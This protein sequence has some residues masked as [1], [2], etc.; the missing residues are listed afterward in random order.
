[1]DPYDFQTGVELARRYGVDAAEV[2]RYLSLADGRRLD[3]ADVEELAAAACVARA[4]G[5]PHAIVERALIAGAS[6]EQVRT[7]IAEGQ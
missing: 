3:P 7:L 1:M 4:R 2:G 6:V 5:V